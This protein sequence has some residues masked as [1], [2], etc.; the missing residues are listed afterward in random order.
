MHELNSMVEAARKMANLSEE[1]AEAIGVRS[2]RPT[3][4]QRFLITSMV[5]EFEAAG[6][7]MIKLGRK[8]EDATRS[9]SL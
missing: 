4:L 8:L 9:D 2:I 6:E 1:I 5:A 7:E 3:T